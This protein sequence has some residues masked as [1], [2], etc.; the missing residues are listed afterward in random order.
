MNRRYLLKTFGL[1]ALG[2]VTIRCNSTSKNLPKSKPN[3]VVIMAD[4]MGFSDLGCYGGEIQT[5][6]I[7]KLAE[8]GLRYTQFYNTSRCCP[9]R[10][11]LLTG[12]YAHQTGMGWMTAADLGSP[13]Y[14][15]DINNN[16]ITIAEVLKQAGY[17]TYMS[18]KWH[19]TFDEYMG[20]DGPKH[21]WPLQRRFDHYYGPLNGGGSY[22]H[23][24]SL[25]HDNTSLP[26][27]EKDYYVTEAISKYATKYIAEHA[28]TKPDQ[29]FFLYVAYTAPHFPLHAKPEDIARY[30]GRYTKG[31]DTLRAERYAK[32]IELGIIDQDWQMAEMDNDVKKW[33]EMNKAEK[34]EMA[35]RLAIY[36]AQIDDMD[37]GVG[38]I[39]ESLKETGQ[40]ENTLIMFLSDNGGTMEFIS[41][42][43]KSFEA[44]GTAS[45]YESVRKPWATASN[46]PFRKFKQ[47]V[48]EGGIATPLIMHWPNRIKS[49]GDL[50]HQMGH[51]IDI[52][53]TCI[54]VADASYPNEYKGYKIIPLEGKSLVPTFDNRPIEREA[55]YWEHQATRAIRLGKW[56]L[57]ADK[58]T[59]PRYEGEWEL[60][61]MKEDRTELNNFAEKYPERV[62]TMAEM[63]H[64][65]AER[66]NVLP[67]DG[68]GWFPR[69]EKKEK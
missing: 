37:Q 29:P 24:R 2:L 9:T 48:H 38:Q 60:Y 31:W 28:K 50:R 13:G 27:P 16:C 52:M 21:N 26:V 67:L 40:F 10:A 57:V 58:N 62:K 4:D 20:P 3:I 65:W 6:N 32:L 47:W 59:G 41:R 63:W 35:K 22:F 8:K 11:S 25:T 19:V 54:D 15:G 12:L 68:R 30:K 61:D 64:Q 69:L 34:Q 39:I 42:G 14:T 53:A 43:D 1:V 55:L 44:L 23:T 5:P 66:C 49:H 46:T 51:V 36:A 17:S 56:K 18:G 45:S 33:E 7:D